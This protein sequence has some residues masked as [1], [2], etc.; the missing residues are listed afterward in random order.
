M[1]VIKITEQQLNRLNFLILSEQD[2]VSLPRNFE[3][4]PEGN[5]NWRSNQPTLTQLQY[6]IEKYNIDNVVRMNGDA[7]SGGVSKSNEKDLVEGMGVNYY[8]VN[9]HKYNSGDKDKGIGYTKSIEEV[10]PI[11]EEG[12]TLIHCTAGMDR[13]GYMVAK[14]LQDNFNWDKDR[15]WEYTVKFNNWE[16]HIC[17]NTSNKG[18]IKYMEAFY[19]LE[20]WCKT[21]D[22]E[23]NCKN[24]RDIVYDKKKKNNNTPTIRV[25]SSGSK[26]N[27]FEK[28]VDGKLI[29]RWGKNKQDDVKLIQKML[30][31]LGYDLG[32]HGID[33]KFGPD[34]QK[35]VKEFQ[36]DVFTDYEEWDGIVGPN[37]Y[38]ELIVD[39]DSIAS[40]EN[41]DRKELL[42]SI[43]P[44]EIN[45]IDKG[46]IGRDK[47]NINVVTT[48]NDP[49]M[50]FPAGGPDSGKAMVG[51]LNGDWDVS[52]PRALAIA[53]MAKDYFGVSISSQKRSRKNTAGGNISQH[54]V[55]STKSYAVDLNVPD[56][57]PGSPKDSEGDLLWDA[58]VDYLGKPGL[59]SGKWQNVIFE[60]YRYN[61]GWRVSGHYNHI[62]VGVED[63]EQDEIYK[64]EEVYKTILLD[65]GVNPTAEKMKFLYAWRQAES[66]TP[67]NPSH[68]VA[69]NNPF[70][71]TWSYGNGSTSSPAPF[72]NCLKHKNGSKPGTVAMRNQYGDQW[73]NYCKS[74]VRHY[75]TIEDGINYT[76]K[77]LNLGYYDDLTD[78]LR[79]DN[80]SAME[81]ASSPSLST[82]GTGGGVKRVLEYNTLNPK[83]IYRSLPNTY[84]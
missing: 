18:Y 67:T 82:W 45:K 40:E 63:K 32:I 71:S 73:R 56:V 30:Y 44:K 51:G 19:T 25:P 10:L 47:P 42:K 33:G 68:H 55:G 14:Y 37:T 60:G 16:N 64:D 61:L 11:L 52:M 31:I 35:A 6:I 83:L 3:E 21:Y 77:T 23:G 49:V 26:S 58:I 1:S 28:D 66:G 84:A 5:N 62:H 8:W 50:G 22:T 41:I 48:Y 78:M 12:N 53:R 39:I 79:D 75:P 72:Y 9:A 2:N 20:E 81:L 24:C 57:S 27:D 80:I 70:N 76:V 59:S 4:V 13:T 43:D 36:K 34:T 69:S 29:Q 38:E 15:L 65:L 54:W 74:G 7:D 46:G 17:N